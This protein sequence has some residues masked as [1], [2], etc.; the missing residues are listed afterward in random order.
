MVTLANFVSL[1]SFLSSVTALGVERCVVCCR[2]IVAELLLILYVQ[3]EIPVFGVVDGVVVI[4]IIVSQ[5]PIAVLSILFICAGRAL[6]Q[7]P[8][9]ARDR[10]ETPFGFGSPSPKTSV[11][12]SIVRARTIAPSHPISTMH[13]SD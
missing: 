12:Q 13:P 6:D 1:I 2:R 7:K 4:G 11:P 8:I 5:L 10:D 9:R 3:R